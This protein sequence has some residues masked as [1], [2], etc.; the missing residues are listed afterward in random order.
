MSAQTGSYASQE[1]LVGEALDEQVGAADA[2]SD[3]R[4]A[5]WILHHARTRA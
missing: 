2:P 5:R 4:S 3:E 1:R